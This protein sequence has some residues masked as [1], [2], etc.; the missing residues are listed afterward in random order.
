[1]LQAAG[2]LGRSWIQKC[3]PFG[4]GALA[5]HCGPADGKQ[6]RRAGGDVELAGALVSAYHTD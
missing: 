5:S 3:S 6:A 2:E 1:M 4:R